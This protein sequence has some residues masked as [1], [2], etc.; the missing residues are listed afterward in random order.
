MPRP[1]KKP[2]SRLSKS[3][4]E[5]WNHELLTAVKAGDD[6]LVVELLEIGADPNVRDARGNPVLFSAVNGVAVGFCVADRELR[7]IRAL[8]AAGADPE[9]DQVAMRMASLAFRAVCSAI[10]NHDAHKLAE[11]L[12]VDAGEAQRLARQS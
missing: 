11:A 8:L 12:G 9:L 7:T 2:G 6:R 1:K 5:A 4:R 10:E 3:E